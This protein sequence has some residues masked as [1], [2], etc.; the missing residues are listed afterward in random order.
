LE[1][2]TNR[3][4]D[5]TLEAFRERWPGDGYFDRNNRFRETYRLFREYYKG[6]KVLDVG[7]WP[8]DFA[9]VLSMLG[10]DVAII[11]KD[12]QR[13]TMKVYSESDGK[14]VLGG[15]HNL[16]DK[17]RSY[18]VNVI[19]C[20]IEMERMPIGDGSLDFV[21]LTEV[22]AHM[23]TRP[24]NALREIRRVLSPG[25][26]LLLTTPNLL[27]LMNRISFIFGLAK[28]DTL[29]LPFDALEAEERLGHA[30]WFRSFS[31]P[32]ITDLLERTGF[33]IQYKGY[34]HFLKEAA[35]VPQWSFYGMRMKTWN[36][37]SGVITP[38]RNNIFIVAGRDDK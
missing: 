26:R 33:R 35:G 11:D 10:I 13:Q 25:G 28:Y 8:G 34:R 12:P 24:L 9:L 3:K 37:L 32:E 16:S 22:L 18:G 21:I 4:F 6:G 14:Y 1:L 30:G 23:R 20:D 2:P 27:T 31:M 19:R 7:G 17:S 36:Y 29:D 5:E 38:M 15:V